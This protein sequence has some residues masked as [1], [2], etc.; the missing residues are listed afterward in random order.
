MHLPSSPSIE[1]LS[2]TLLYTDRQVR[3]IPLVIITLPLLIVSSI[4]LLLLFNYFRDAYGYNDSTRIPGP[5]MA[6]L[7]DLWLYRAATSGR[8]SILVHEL[9][10]R[11][12]PFVRI[13][14]NHISISDPDA[15]REVYAYSGTLKSDFYDAFRSTHGT[16][17]STRDK[18]DHGRRR[19]MIAPV[20]SQT[21]IVDFQ[22]YLQTIIASMLQK[23]DSLCDKAPQKSEE[24]VQEVYKKDGR[25]WLNCADWYNFLTFDIIGDLAFGS[26][27]GMIE[28]GCDR[29]PYIDVND[30]TRKVQYL[31]A[32]KILDEREL[33]AS[34]LGV[35]PP[36]L[37]GLFKKTPSFSVGNE[38]AKKLYGMS[39]AA[40]TKRIENPNDRKD[41]LGGLLRGRDVNGKSMDKWELTAESITQIIGGSDTT[42]II[43]C[44]I[45]YHLAMN[46]TILRK[47]QAELDEALGLE[48]GKDDDAPL[49]ES[50]VPYDLIKSLP[51][52]DAVVNEGLRLQSV[53]AV[54]LPRV[55][56]E[57]G[58]VVRGRFFKPG[59]IL[60]VPI[61]SVHRDETVWG[62]DVD[63]FR[64]E[65][66]FEGNTEAMQKAFI[67]FS[68]GPRACIA[69]NLAK[70][71]LLQVAATIFRRYDIAPLHE[72]MDFKIR[73]GFVR[74]MSSC[75]IGIRRR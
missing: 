63:G 15:I 5:L 46:P 49:E 74:K 48:F 23:W 21:S 2:Y 40:V 47:L 18:A 24:I 11:Y 29:A 60:S 45:T 30:S 19:K 61:Y 26:P 1:Y 34:T 20:F 39:N 3:S 31:P 57:G 7:S 43:I 12:G 65:R 38:A 68:W 9:H 50:V 25:A 17:F 37:R 22:P 16:I 54:G 33:W 4:T 8:R 56:Q 42:S 27:F 53:V 32:I 52:L 71:E 73:E 35:V 72:N 59:S 36:I 10:K 14:P 67:P 41:V 66:W 51:Y 28:A 64:P 58:L 69:K 55:V 62:A 6:R 75:F 13:A 44:A 70:M